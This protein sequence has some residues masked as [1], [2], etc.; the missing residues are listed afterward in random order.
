MKLKNDENNDFLN[1][2]TI[3]EILV[4]AD[5]TRIGLRL[6]ELASEIQNAEQLKKQSLAVTK[7]RL[8]LLSGQQCIRDLFICL[9]ENVINWPDVYEYFCF[10]LK[11]TSNCCKCNHMSESETS[12]LYIEIDVPLE[13]GSM[14]NVVEEFFNISSLVGRLCEDGCQTFAETEKRS[15]IRLAKETEFF[16]VV[17]SRAIYKNGIELSKTKL[18]A[19]ENVFIR[20]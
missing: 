1:P 12:Q 15:R 19:T 5:D 16:I 10:I 8:N 6:S 17:L 2:R 11:H 20:Y 18:I 4:T 7:T 13:N 14:H 9:E 3:K